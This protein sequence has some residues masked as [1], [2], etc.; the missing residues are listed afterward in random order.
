MSARTRPGPAAAG[1]LDV[2]AAVEQMLWLREIDRALAALAREDAVL[3]GTVL[4]PY[5]GLEAI[6]VGVT[7]ARRSGDVVFATHRGFGHVLAWAEDPG[8]VVAEVLGRRSGYAKGRGGHMHVVDVDSGIGGTNGIVGAGLPLA[9]GAAHAL[10]LRA[11]GSVAVAFFGDGAVNTG[12]FHETMNLASVWRLPLVFVCEDNGWTEAMRSADMLGADALSAR[13]RAYRMP[14]CEVD[15]RSVRE[16]HAAALE[17]MDRARAGGGPSF[18]C[19]TIVRPAGHYLG[20]AQ[21]YRDASERDT[22]P[23]ADPVEFC[24]AEAGCTSHERQDMVARAEAAA[25]A[26]V[27]RAAALDPPD[28][29]ILLEDGDPA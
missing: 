4:H 16:V 10:R 8:R 25:R 13:A 27:E 24:L 2:R 20:D 14:A 26:L 12:A 19:C 9:A 11:P 17:A 7:K 22:D 29:A 6:A 21:R 15:G 23:L 5:T 28:L 1:G 3:D 18:V